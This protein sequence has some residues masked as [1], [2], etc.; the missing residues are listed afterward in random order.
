MKVFAHVCFDFLMPPDSLKATFMERVQ[1]EVSQKEQELL[2]EAVWTRCELNVM[3][4][5]GMYLVHLY[6]NR[7]CHS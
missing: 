4:M 1:R 7:I 3:E 2:D 5:A 6:Q